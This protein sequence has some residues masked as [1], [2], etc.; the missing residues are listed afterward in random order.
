MPLQKFIQ[1]AK[2][3]GL[4]DK[5]IKSEVINSIIEKNKWKD[6]TQL[7]SETIELLNLV[8]LQ[9]LQDYIIYGD[10]NIYPL[11]K[12]PLHFE[13]PER[14]NITKNGSIA[15][16]IIDKFYLKED[17]TNPNQYIINTSHLGKDKNI[18]LGDSFYDKYYIKDA[19]A[20]G[21]ALDNE[22]IIT[23]YHVTNAIPGG[24]PSM[25]ENYC[26]VF[27]IEE[28]NS[29]PLIIPKMNVVY[30]N[31]EIA[32]CNDSNYDY[33]LLNIKNKLPKIVKPPIISKN[34]NIANE[35]YMI[36]HPHNMSLHVS[37][38][39]KVNT[40]SHTF[41]MAYLDGLEHNS[42]SPVFDTN[43][44]ELVGFLTGSGEKDFISNGICNG[45]NIIKY[46]E[47]IGK[48]VIYIH[49]ILNHSC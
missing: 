29:N 47:S 31:N 27:G 37:L 39:A 23:S 7:P 17:N 30:F 43:T 35:V 32:S 10:N 33:I 8:S 13:I 46:N 36:G 28:I 45:T 49:S 18:C 48:K 5:Q 38:N 40:T 3:F 19:I 34:T 22:T 6:D 25:L 21:F 11:S 2:E 24:I 14:K 4:S 1:S 42:G 16:I 44:N 12:L 41:F 26:I 20:T 15:G 9:H